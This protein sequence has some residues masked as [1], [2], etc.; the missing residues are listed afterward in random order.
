MR[1]L[2]LLIIS[3]S[4]FGCRTEN[5]PVQLLT[6]NEWRDILKSTLPLAEG[7]K[8]YIFKEYENINSKDVISKIYTTCVDLGYELSDST[9]SKIN[10]RLNK[11]ITNRLDTMF[12][13]RFISDTNRVSDNF[14]IYSEPFYVND[15]ILCIS[16]INKKV[17]ENTALQWVIFLKKKNESFKIIEFYDVKKDQFFRPAPL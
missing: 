4:L 11:P 12:S 7:E 15:E 9:L 3:L 2:V 6:D 1:N 8:P 13:I 5:K 10:N 16:M 17:L 14:V